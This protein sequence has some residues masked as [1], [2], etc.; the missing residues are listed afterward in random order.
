[1]ST[2]NL[3]GSALGE[4]TRPSSPT[5]AR[6]Y[7]A[8]P[9][10]EYGSTHYHQSV[11]VLRARFPDAVILEGLTLFHD[12]GH[13]RA[14]WPGVLDSITA[15]VFVADPDGWIG[16]GVW[17]EIQAARGRVPVH[18][19]T[20]AGQLVPLAEVTCSSPDPENWTHHVRVSVGQE[21]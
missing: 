8:A 19:L 6:I 5:R 1:M 15:V 18:F 11:A 16:R 3:P 21:A 17:S 12:T 2:I 13:W 10:S 14:A 9:K 7:F 20:D 4:K